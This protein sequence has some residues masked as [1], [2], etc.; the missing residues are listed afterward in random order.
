LRRGRQRRYALIEVKR[1]RHGGYIADSIYKALGY[2]ADFE[3]VFE[4][5][6]G[7]RG[8]LALWDTPDSGGSTPG[9]N[10]PHDS[11]DSGDD[12]APDT[13]VLATRHTYRYEARRLLEGLLAELAD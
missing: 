4:G 11:G 7:V 6:R 9:V 13:L 8:L 12:V 10:P 3:A 2:L 5:Q 1:T